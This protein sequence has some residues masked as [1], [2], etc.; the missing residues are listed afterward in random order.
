MLKRL[1]VVACA[2]GCLAAVSPAGAQDTAGSSATRRV[3]A[4]IR[5]LQRESDRL[6]GSARTLVGELRKLEIAR[7]LRVAEAT[8]ADAAVAGATN[9]L[10]ATT[11][12]LTALERERVDQLPGLRAQLVG[13][14]KRGAAGY[15]PLLLGAG[16]LREFGRASRILAVMSAR[17]RRR[18]EAHRQ[19]LDALRKQRADLE[20]RTA[21]LRERQAAAQQ[22]RSAARRAVAAHAERIAEVDA[23][24]DL[25]AQY[26]GELEIARNGL[27]QSLTARS[28]DQPAAAPVIP[29]DPFRGALEWPVDGRLTARFGQPANRLGGSAVRNGIEISAA[30]G[31]AVR[32]VHGGTVAHADP[33]TGFGNLVILDHGGGHYSLYGYLGAIG[34]A[35]GQTV[36]SG[37]EV[38]QVGPSPAGPPALY[39]EMRIDGRSVDPVQWLQPRPR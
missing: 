20:A 22:A 27:M 31:V 9:D 12:R 1:S 34:V 4:R 3:E 23:R 39:F 26:V 18:I 14:Y 11:E 5:A 2:I 37:S 24:R 7:D 8:Q 10:A 32:A 33:F 38:G 15:L 28:S 25:T 19:T 36:E 35:R 21:A 30:A 16:N 13:L 17:Q 6:A 29:L